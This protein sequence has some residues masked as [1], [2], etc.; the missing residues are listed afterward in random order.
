ML[1]ILRGK[2]TYISSAIV[3]IALG[4]C[5]YFKVD[6]ETLEMVMGIGGTVIAMFIR[7]GIQSGQLSEEDQKDLAIIIEL[8][9]DT[10]KEADKVGFVEIATTHQ[11]DNKTK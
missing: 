7:S 8:S 11:D 5:W 10:L 6:R 1:K 9:K 4:L 3:I 2:K